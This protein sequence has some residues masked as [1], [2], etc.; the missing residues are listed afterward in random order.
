MFG[1]HRVD[2]FHCRQDTQLFAVGTYLQVFF[3]H[4]SLRGLQYEAGNL[5]IGE[6]HYL[7]LAEHVGWKFFQ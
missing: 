1:S 6:T 5:E 7:G 3:L 2:A 4:V